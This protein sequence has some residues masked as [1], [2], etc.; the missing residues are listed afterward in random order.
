MTQPLP[1]WMKGIEK[2]GD[3]FIK[4]TKPFVSAVEISNLIDLSSASLLEQHHRILIM[5]D[6]GS[7]KTHFIGTMP[8]PFV[9]DFDRGLNTLQGKPVKAMAFGPEDWNAFAAEVKAWKGGPMYG[10]ETFCVDSL[11]M[12]SEAA[13]NA[14]LTKSGRRGGQPTVQDWGEAIRRVKDMLG[15]ITTLPCNVVVTAHWQLV[16][17]E[18]LGDVQYLPLIFGKDLPHRLGIWFDEVY[19]TLVRTKIEGTSSVTSY[20]LQVKPDARS[21]IIKS[22]MNSTGMLFNQFEAPDFNHL[23]K[24]VNPELLHEQE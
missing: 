7:G 4:A 23:Q 10:C 2:D 11:S 8:K 20:D 12:A 19:S 22:R 21:R 5:G 3:D 24:K 15:Y 17:D 9:C 18:I 16:R 1:T 14:V 6:S 13:M